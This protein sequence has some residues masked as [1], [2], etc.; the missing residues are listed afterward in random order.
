MFAYIIWCHRFLLVWI[1]FETFRIICTQLHRC[2]TKVLVISSNFNAEMLHFNFSIFS[3]WY[4][5]WYD[6]SE[7]F[8]HFMLLTVVGLNQQTFNMSWTS[9]RH[10]VGWKTTNA[11]SQNLI[12]AAC[13]L[14]D[15]GLPTQTLLPPISF[16]DIS[17]LIHRQSFCLCLSFLVIALVSPRQ[18]TT[19]QIFH[20]PTKIQKGRHPT[21]DHL[22]F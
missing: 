2:V 1:L 11:A 21:L 19:S 3:R 20:L 7:H 8:H 22:S 10:V 14:H 16:I 12:M 18:N 6:G 15:T 4:D 9:K 13:C 17:F 5:L